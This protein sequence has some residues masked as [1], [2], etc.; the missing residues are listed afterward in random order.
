MP[1]IECINPLENREF[2]ASLGNWAGDAAW[3]PGPVQTYNGLMEFVCE[4]FGANKAESLS[5]RNI[6]IPKNKNLLLGILTG[7]DLIIWGVPFF[8]V[9]IKDGI[10]T[11]FNLLPAIIPITPFQYT[12][13]TFTTPSQWNRQTGSIL[14]TAHFPDAAEG[15]V[16]IKNVSLIYQSLKAQ[17]LP[18]I[19]IG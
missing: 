5:F 14:I 10:G 16:F 19:G 15:S 3:N 11:V 1:T 18:I 8:T 9:V 12:Y 17:Y 6:N 13:Y 7:L 4:P 2:T